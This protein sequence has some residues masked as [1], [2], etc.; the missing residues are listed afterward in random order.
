LGQSERQKERIL[1]GGGWPGIGGKTD[2]VHRAVSGFAFEST[3][4]KR[5]NEPKITLL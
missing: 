3:R 5:E 2:P 4:A 1:E